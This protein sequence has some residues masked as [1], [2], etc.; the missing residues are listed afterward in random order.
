MPIYEFRC[1][2]C[3][4]VQEIIVSSS[5]ASEDV[6]MKCEACE[7]EVLERLMSTVSYAMG[8]PK[9]GPQPSVSTKS[10]GENTCGTL[11]IPGPTR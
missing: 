2:Q 5:K 3:G 6:E 4:N 9:S 11:N 10:C 8:N 7:G 1:A